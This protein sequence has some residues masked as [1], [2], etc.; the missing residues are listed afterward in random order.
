MSLTMMREDGSMKMNR[1]RF[2]QLGTT[3]GIFGLCGCSS[4]NSDDGGG[5]SSGEDG[6]TMGNNAAEGDKYPNQ[7]IT[8]I[9]PWSQGGGTDRSTRA[10][11]PTWASVMGGE[12][13]VQNFSGGSTQVG[14]ERIFSSNADGYTVGM[15]NLPQMQATWLFQDA[16][17]RTDDFNYIGTNHADPTMWFAPQD[18][19]YG[20]MNEFLE[21]ARNNEVN[22]GLTSAVGNTALSALLVLDTY[23]VNMNLI[24]L[25]GGSGV[26]Q[27]ILAGDVDAAVNQP[28]AFNPSNIGK[29][30]TLGS[31]TPE[32]QEL[33]P[34]TPSFA[35]LGLTDLPLV[36]Q[37]LVQWK[38]MV[39]PAP[40]KKEYPDRWEMLVSTY[41]EAM[42]TD[43]YRQ[44][45][46]E[47]GN[48]DQIIR[49][50]GPDETG[51]IV[52]QNTD[53]MSQFKPLFDEYLG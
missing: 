4:Q 28:W 5:S 49:F 24:N 7:P 25:E 30:T 11:T 53:F 40:I 1:R 22:V 31:H 20:D 50:N 32:S 14:G 46:S 26:R 33:W 12:F 21:F 23:D 34:D 16:T 41:E 19:S 35:N 44:R 9:V 3:A 42:M 48:L 51:K 38:L 18:S 47:Q 8:V 29:V 15:W 6:G 43:S 27:A 52:K 2:I 13:T 39:A 10:L 36:D 17:Y 45:A 37:G